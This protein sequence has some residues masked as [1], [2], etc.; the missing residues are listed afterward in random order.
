RERANVISERAA[1]EL[2]EQ[3]RTVLKKI[4][5]FQEM[6]A[7]NR[8]FFIQLKQFDQASLD[9]AESRV[10]FD[11]FQ[12]PENVDEVASEI[13]AYRNDFTKVAN[14]LDQL[15]TVDRWNGFVEQY[16]ES[17]ERFHVSQNAARKAI[18]FVS[19]HKSLSGMPQEFSGLIR[20]TPEWTFQLENVVPTQRKILL[21]LEAE[22]AQK[23]WTFSPSAD[24]CYYLLAP[25]KPGLNDYVADAAGSV[26]QVEIPNNAEE[27]RSSE[28][29]Q[30]E[31][32]LELS[33]IARSIPDD[34]Q[35]Q[36]SARWY[37]GWCEFLTRVQETNQ[38]DSI[39]QYVLMRDCAK[40]LASS[41]YFFQ[42]RLEPILK[43][44]NLPQLEEGASVDRF[45]TETQKLQ[46]IRQLAKSRLDFLPKNHLVVDKTTAQ[47]DAQV[48]R[49]AF[50]YRRIGW[51]DRD[52][53]D[54]WK[55]RR[56]SDGELPEGD[57]YVSIPSEENEQLS[58]WF[59][60]GSSNGKRTTLK[61]ATNNV[62]RGSIVF[63]RVSL[64]QEKTIV[65]RASVERFFD[66]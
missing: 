59:K 58:Q 54:E 51:L 34:L 53:A 29:K 31:F 62:P 9:P 64:T 42:R 37:S 55:C 19:Q 21:R 38:L 25:P 32:L 30:T 23:Y 46:K 5:S 49:V 15:E 50:V 18:E 27:T 8:D 61:L 26:K 33:A 57:L 12:T 45:Q 20:R 65:K 47:L 52:F 41:D 48:E 2:V 3:A 43:M 14:R 60:I 16:G 17:L 13:A 4:Q 24:K 35:T 6:L 7:Q 66:R 39:L 56:P 63:C 44:L 40:L 11:R 28:S 10:F 36:D 22:I 1:P